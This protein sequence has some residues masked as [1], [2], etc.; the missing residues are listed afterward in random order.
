[1]NQITLSVVVFRYLNQGVISHVLCEVDTPVKRLSLGLLMECYEN[2]SNFGFEMPRFKSPGF[3]YMNKAL[4][5][6]RVTTSF[7]SDIDGF[8][9]DLVTPLWLI[10]PEAYAETSL[11]IKELYKRDRYLSI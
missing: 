2:A 9:L 5:L 6:H 3:Y 4:K 8:E 10:D 11:K 7:P 1:M